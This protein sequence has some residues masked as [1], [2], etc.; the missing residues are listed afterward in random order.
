[1]RI[2]ALKPFDLLDPLCEA[3]LRSVSFIVLL[4]VMNGAS[5]L[6]AL[7]LRKKRPVVKCDRCAVSKR[8]FGS[9]VI[10]QDA[11]LVAMLSH[12]PKLLGSLVTALTSTQYEQNCLSVYRLEQC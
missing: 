6:W 8:C 9:S 5:I 12:N 2:R 7:L 10:L 3:L 4:D 11:S 1:M